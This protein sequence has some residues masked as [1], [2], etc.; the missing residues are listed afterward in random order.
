MNVEKILESNITNIIVAAIVALY[1]GNVGKIPIPEKI[2]NLFKNDIF[3]LVFLS[4]L[5]FVSMTKTPYIGIS[6]S[7]IFVIIMW[8]V[9]ESI[10]KENFINM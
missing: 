1:V 2:K 8:N 9:N 10:F 6:L 4:M 3:R 5:I 7:I